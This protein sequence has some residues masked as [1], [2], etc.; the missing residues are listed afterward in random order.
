MVSG[1]YFKRLLLKSKNLY[2]YV[3]LMSILYVYKMY[4]SK[5]KNRNIYIYI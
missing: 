2:N 3:I 4:V 1:L 5:K